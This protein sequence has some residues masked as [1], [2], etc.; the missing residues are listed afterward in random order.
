MNWIILMIGSLCEVGWL[1]GMKYSDGFSRLWPAVV[2]ILFMIASMI[3][4]GLAVR[5]IP[6]ST[7]YAAWTG[8]SIVL[9]SVV[10]LLLFHEEASLLRLGSIAV[11]VIGLVGLKISE[12]G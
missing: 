6:A 4:L 7:A 9:A 10:G 2:M 8:V 12:G 1:V 11:V 3:C 5:T